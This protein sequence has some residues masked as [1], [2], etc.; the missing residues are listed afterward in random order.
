MF[1]FFFC[2]GLGL[3]TASCIYTAFGVVRKI[4]ASVRSVALK[5]AMKLILFLLLSCAQLA[6]AIGIGDTKTVRDEYSLFGFV[7]AIVLIF[8]IAFLTRNVS[9]PQSPKT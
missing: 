2:F 1:D 3:A 5:G 4:D 7:L 9:L 6:I 8:I